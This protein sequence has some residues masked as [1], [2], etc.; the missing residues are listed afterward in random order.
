MPGLEKL[1]LRTLIVSASLALMLS[2]V[3]WFFLGAIVAVGFVDS[4]SAGRDLSEAWLSNFA[5]GWDFERCT[6]VDAKSC[7]RPEAANPWVVHKRKSKCG[8]LGEISTSRTKHSRLQRHASCESSLHHTPQTTNTV[9]MARR[10]ARCYRYCKN[11][12]RLIG[13]PGPWEQIEDR[14]SLEEVNGKMKRAEILT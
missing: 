9:A 2:V 8:G 11:K 6:D 14:H 1:R 13:I 5:R 12:V 4:S 10:P 3:F 7:C